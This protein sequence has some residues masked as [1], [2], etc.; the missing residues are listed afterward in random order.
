MGFSV[1]NDD[2]DVLYEEEVFPDGEVLEVFWIAPAKKLG[3]ASLLKFENDPFPNWSGSELHQLVDDL[4]RLK[5]HW[6]TEGVDGAGEFS[7]T[8]H[9]VGQ[10]GQA[11]ISWLQ[12]M[13]RCNFS[14]KKAAMLAIS[15][16][17]KVD[18]LFD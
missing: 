2:F 13:S 9:V 11:E 18:M 5:R 17:A 4:D 7:F 3:L 1:L 16:K 15:E 8:Q 12:E 14:L 6:E 10:D